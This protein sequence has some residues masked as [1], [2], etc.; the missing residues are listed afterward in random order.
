MLHFGPPGGV[1]ANSLCSKAIKLATTSRRQL[2]WQMSQEVRRQRKE[3]SCQVVVQG[4]MTEAEN[5]NTW[6][7]HKAR[8][9]LL[10]DMLT[11]ATR[12]HR[13]QLSFEASHS[14]NLDSLS[15]ISI[16]TFRST[17][18]TGAVLRATHQQRYSY[19][20]ASLQVRKQTS[21]FDRLCSAPAKLCM[22]TL[23]LLDPQLQG[24]LRP[25][26]KKGEVWTSA[27]FLLVLWEVNIEHAYIKV[28]V[29]EP[30]IQAVEARMDSGIKRLV[31]GMTEDAEDHDAKGKG[32]KDSKGG[33]GKGS[34]KGGKSGKHKATI[35]VSATAFRHEPSVVRDRLGSLH[36][37]KYPIEIKIRAIKEQ[38]LIDRGHAHLHVIP[39]GGDTGTR[40]RSAKRRSES[41]HG[42]SKRRSNTPRRYQQMPGN[43]PDPWMQPAHQQAVPAAHP[44]PPQAPAPAP[45]MPSAASTAQPSG[46]SSD[47]LQQGPVMFG[48]RIHA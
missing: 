1:W 15:K 6:E 23:T 21:V 37:A 28:F 11:R 8:D 30:H 38:Q 26:W 32:G 7:A 2:L 24:T 48:Q 10:L 36:M 43:V 13:D 22:E 33:G 3:M 29:P 18:I 35:P 16:L 20:T 31:F 14:T 45:S 27:G 12:L 40:A 5:S 4:W 17:A 39:G 47:Q 34:K 46:M 25:D 9:Q 19:G 44:L 41:H 42:T